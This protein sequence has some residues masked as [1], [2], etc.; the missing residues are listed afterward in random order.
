MTLSRKTRVCEVELVSRS[1]RFSR[2]ARFLDLRLRKWAKGLQN[3]HRGF[4]SR[5]RLSIGPVVRSEGRRAPSGRDGGRAPMARLVAH[6]V[7]ARCGVHRV[8]RAAC[9]PGRGDVLGERALGGW[10]RRSGSA[11]LQVP[12]AMRLSNERVTEGSTRPFLAFLLTG[13]AGRS[14]KGKLDIAALTGSGCGGR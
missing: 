10:P 5:R 4:D 2:F 11:A 8:P 1:A 9:A 13:Q 12:R 14:A 7:R 6:G 3:P